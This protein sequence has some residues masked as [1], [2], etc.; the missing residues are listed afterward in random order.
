MEVL[1]SC[2]VIP[3][4]PLKLHVIFSVNIVHTEDKINFNCIYLPKEEYH[5]TNFTCIHFSAD[6][7]IELMYNF[8]IKKSTSIFSSIYFVKVVRS[9]CQQ[10]M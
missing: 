7:N 5:I 3:Q 2:H 6:M 10:I 1:S 9:L 4:N 8:V